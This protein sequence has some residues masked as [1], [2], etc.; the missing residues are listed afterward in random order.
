M[1]SKAACLEQLSGGSVMSKE[2]DVFVIGSGPAGYGAAKKLVESGVKTRIFEKNSYFGG[3]CATF[4][5]D[6]GF[7]FDDGPHISFSSNEHIRH[8][9]DKNADHDL[10]EF[11]PYVNNYWH[12]HWIKHPAITS[13]YGLPPDLNTTILSEIAELVFNNDE[14]GEVNNYEEWLFRCYG[15]TYARQF[16]MEYTVKYHTTEAKNLTT[17][18]LGPRLYQPDLKEVVYGMLAPE[19]PDKHYVS[20]AWY[21]NKDGFSNFLSET[22]EIAPLRYNAEVTQVDVINRT[23]TLNNS[24][25]LGY[26]YLVSSMPIDML[27]SRIVG[28]PDDLKSSAKA[29]ACT[30]CVIV[31]LGI[32]RPDLSKAHWTYIYDQDIC[33]AR[34]SFPHKFSAKTVPEGCSS[35]QVEIYFSDKYRPMSLSVD[36]CVDDTIRDLIKIGVLASPKEVIFSKAWV[37]PYAQVIFDHDRKEAVDSIHAFL[38][39]NNIEY[40]GRFGEWA[41]IWSDQSFLSG[42]AASE[43]ILPYL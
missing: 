23:V 42:E 32:N 27:V 22:T 39:E 36:Q 24:E 9:F 41:Y 14:L 3:H 19:S 4:K 18:W 29:L 26:D 31:N 43:R 15:E 13:M 17:D 1:T 25:T 37:S 40:C 33:F 16:P 21:P 2:K 35:V 11:T 7:I 28:A 12:G 34:L 30:K 8:V 10:S 6:E 38:R 20:Y 5:F